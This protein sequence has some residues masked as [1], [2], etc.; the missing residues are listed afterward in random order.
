MC[1]ALIMLSWRNM[2]CKTI[3]STWLS[4]VFADWHAS[5][6]VIWENETS[7]SCVVN[8]LRNGTNDRIYFLDANKYFMPPSKKKNTSC[9]QAKHKKF[10][11]WMDDLVAMPPPICIAARE[12]HEIYA[13][14][15]LSQSPKW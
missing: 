6:G 9:Q 11:K 12:H 14:K 5:S 2:G 15:S 13:I 4:S 7:S 8:S 1:V 10:C 3:L